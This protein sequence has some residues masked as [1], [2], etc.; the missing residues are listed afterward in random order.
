[1]ILF[2]MRSK[3]SFETIY[4]ICKTKLLFHTKYIFSDFFHIRYT[5][6]ACRVFMGDFQDFSSDVK[7]FPG[8]FN[9]F[10]GLPGLCTRPINMYIVIRQEK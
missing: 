9:R 4:K 3:F 10:P 6:V 7:D 8:L 2:R 1:M 5:Q